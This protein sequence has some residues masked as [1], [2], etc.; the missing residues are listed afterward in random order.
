MRRID[1]SIFSMFPYKRVAFSVH[2]CGSGAESDGCRAKRYAPISGGYTA[3][4]G[5]TFLIICTP[6]Y[7]TVPIHGSFFRTYFECNMSNR[8]MMKSI[9]EYFFE[10]RS[11]NVY[12]SPSGFYCR[13]KQLRAGMAESRD[14]VTQ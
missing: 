7:R 4:Y 5:N 13:G 1:V 10:Q 12:V 11:S 14:P 8:F 6:A 9:A 2:T 3:Y